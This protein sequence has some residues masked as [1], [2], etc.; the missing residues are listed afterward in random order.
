MGLPGDRGAHLTWGRAGHTAW[1][2]E[3]W[4]TKSCKEP[5]VYIPLALSLAI[6]L[7]AAM[8]RPCPPRERQVGIAYTTWHRSTQWQGVW[9]TPELGFYRSDDRA[10]IR[11]HAAW[12]AEAGVDFIWIDWSNDLN[13]QYGITKG[14]PDFDMIEE[15]T[16][17]IFEEYAKL[18]QHPRI[19]IFIGC[20]GDPEGVRDGR[21]TRKADQVY[22]QFVANPR[23]RPLLQ[24]YLGK[25][26]LV[27]YVNT[28]SPWQQGVPQWDDPRFTVR[29]M[30]GFVTQQPP[31]QGPDRLSR[32]G[33]WS[34]EDRG[35][36]TY[37]VHEGQAEQMVVSACWRPDPECPTPG[38]R[39][40]QT[41]RERWA[42]VRR[43]G[44]RFAM[45]TTFNEW[46]LGE[47]PSAEGSRDVEP[48]KEFGHLYM[49]VLKE[50]I[51]LFK[52]GK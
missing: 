13:Y 43:F 22:R 9:G 29:Y 32:Y 7:P 5:R 27:V 18:S 40:G 45:V 47:Q 34:W 28:P 35:D 38:R 17:A 39:N 1:W 3:P 16:V 20:P 23:F 46:V 42:R 25:P 31:L 49:D 11:K 14:R 37:T 24:T 4:S 12:L 51:A 44:P 30:T 21:L 50:Q 48:S 26:L 36:Q 52:K 10:V 15:S 2:V 41:F 6:S 33:Y 8:P 19:S